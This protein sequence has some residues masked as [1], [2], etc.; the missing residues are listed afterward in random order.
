M[1]RESIYNSYA[2]IMG[3]GGGGG[4]IQYLLK[5]LSDIERDVAP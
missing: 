5:S 2:D 1:M 3:G 4:G